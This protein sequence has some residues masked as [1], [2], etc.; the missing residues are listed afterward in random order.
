MR[1]KI[2]VLIVAF[3]MTCALTSCAKLVE[4]VK[5][6]DPYMDLFLKAIETGDYDDFLEICSNEYS[7]DELINIMDQISAY[8]RGDIKGYKRENYNFQSRRY[9]GYTYK[10]RTAQYWVDTDVDRYLVT[11]GL[12]EE[13]GLLPEINSFTVTSSADVENQ[14]W[15]IKW[16]DL[17]AL[18]IGPLLWTVVSAGLIIL[19][20]VLCAKA[21]IRH[22]ALWIL[23][24]LL[25]TVGFTY[26]HMSSNFHLQF[27]L[28]VSLPISYC[29]KY[30]DG[31][32]LLRIMAPVGA[33]I[34]M[35]IRKHLIRKKAA[36]DVRLRYNQIPKAQPP[37]NQS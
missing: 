20:I 8:M 3:L 21:N 17:D 25:G 18:Q 33:M 14:R 11:L 24:S 28:I 10:I 15:L 22:K 26:S 34:F 1:R 37:E 31:S 32:V 16:D 7:D 19:S 35:L 6:M 27:H 4:D 36:Y 2:I 9:N 23:I 29:Y 5:E 12:Q 30:A 13:N